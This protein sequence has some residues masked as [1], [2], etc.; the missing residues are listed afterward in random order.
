MKNMNS[1]KVN[2][3]MPK[4]LKAQIEMYYKKKGYNSLSDYLRSLAIEDIKRG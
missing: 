3:T 4:S 2:I 1:V